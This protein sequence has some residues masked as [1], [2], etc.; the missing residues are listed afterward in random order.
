MISITDKFEE[1]DEALWEELLVTSRNGSIFQTPGFYR[2]SLS[3]AGHEPFIFI[4][5]SDGRYDMLMAGIIQHE[6]NPLTK[7]LSKRAIVNGGIVTRGEVAPGDLVV[8][9]KTACK[10]LKKKAVYL[11]IRNL[12]DYSGMADIF[13][14]AGFK[15]IPHL[16]FHVNVTTKEDAFRQ[17]NQSRRRQIRKSLDFGA[18]IISD[19][20]TEE[21]KEF[22][23]ILDETYRKKVRKPLPREEFFHRFLNSEIGLFLLIRFNNKIIGGIMCPVYDG[24]VIYEWYVAGEDGKYDGIYPSVLATW[25]AIEYAAKNG[26]ETFDFMGAG[27][28]DE[29]YGVREFKSKFGVE[30]VEYGRFLMVFNKTVYNA[31]K[32]FFRRVKRAL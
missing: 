9:L 31:G 14:T 30:Q 22:Y 15:Y 11:E 28:P 21:I 27:S 13:T 24:K 4:G 25:A 19:P 29:Q 18:E 23:G 16:N 6:S 2:F 3:T 7:A 20:T 1:A 10:G 32:M 17:L 26:I 8:F 12:N 5:G